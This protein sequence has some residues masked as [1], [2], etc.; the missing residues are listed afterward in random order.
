MTTKKKIL[1]DITYGM[2][3]RNIVL[4]KSFW[5][6]LSKE[7]EIHLLTPLE[8]N[9]KDQKELNI[10]KIFN[11]S[12]FRKNLFKK[13]ALSINLRILHS[14][15]LMDLSDFFLKQHLGWP[16]V[17]R[18]HETYRGSEN[19]TQALFFWSAVKRTF[20]GKFLKKV[21]QFFPLSHPVN[22]IFKNNK[23]HFMINTHNSEY[24]S[25]LNAQIAKKNR[26]PVISFP[27]GLD[28]VMH[29]PFLFEPDLIFF[30]GEDQEFEFNN[31]QLSWNENLKQSK[32]EILGNLI[33]GTIDQTKDFQ[34]PDL[35]E[36]NNKKKFILFTTMPEDD[37][38]GQID[39]CKTIINYL[40]E[41]KFPHKLVIRVRPGHDEYLW[42]KFKEEHPME[43]ILH[44]PTGVSF[45]KSNAKE[46]IDLEE[47]IKEMSIYSSTLKNSTVVISRALSTTYTDALFVGT[48]AITTQY[49]PYDQER[50]DGF[51]VMWYQICTFYPHYRSGYKFALS[52][53]ELIQFLSKVL[54]NEKKV[55]IDKE[56]EK[57]LK[58]QFYSSSEDIG[59]RAYRIIKNKFG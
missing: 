59:E 57:L 11:S 10:A 46:N 21:I 52:E 45:D 15:R 47:E 42:Q 14:R 26:V 36:T 39:I 8:L 55:L 43:V 51:K 28:N 9:N 53:K 12:Q 29:G 20:L 2:S 4:N 25:V 13:I 23:Y 56:Q 17:S 19:L 32:K 41:N 40:R 16:L 1:V 38:P 35:T 44:I 33:F 24:N 58:K 48:P 54:Q 3:F 31:L 50:S 34:I 18:Y 6:K 5:N 27:M 37:H 7:Y 22:H 30:W 49:F